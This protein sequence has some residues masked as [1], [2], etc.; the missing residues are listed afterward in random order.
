MHC[1]PELFLDSEGPGSRNAMAPKRKPR[2]LPL[3]PDECWLKVFAF[4]EAS[5]LSGCASGLCAGALALSSQ[6]QLWISLL[7]VDFC[8]SFPQRALLRTWLSMHEHFHP[9]QLYIY[10]RRE[11]LLDLDIARTELQQRGEQAREQDRKQRRLRTLNFV[12]VRVTHLLLCACVLAC[13]L[14]LWL[15]VDQVVGWSFYIIFAP[16][17]AFE[18]FVFVSATVAFVIYFLRGSSGWT[19]YWNRL[20]GA[21]RWLILYTSPAEGIAVLLLASSVVPLLACAL[22]GDNLLPS[23]YPRFT[24]PFAA[25]WLTSLCF[26]CSLVRRRSFSAACVGSFVLLWMPMIS[27]SVLLYLRLSVFPKLPAYR[28][29]QTN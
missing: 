17:F 28:G 14:L 11:H 6:P 24:L 13:S 23:K 5:E 3:L 19:F 7:H 2:L 18:V 22:E 9:R 15:R 20:R 4:L 29:A 21:V 27:L 10:K 1:G 26:V 25:F 8:A 16:F 12:L